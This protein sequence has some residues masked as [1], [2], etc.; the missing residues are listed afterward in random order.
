LRA[1][2]VQRIIRCGGPVEDD[3]ANVIVAQLLYLDAID[4]NRVNSKK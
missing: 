2:S 4:P 3:M 1:V